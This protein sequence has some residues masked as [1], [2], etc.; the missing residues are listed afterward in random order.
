MIAQEFQCIPEDGSVVASLLN[1][2]GEVIVS[3]RS[4]HPDS[5]WMLLEAAER[6]RAA[7]ALLLGYGCTD[8]VEDRQMAT[9]RAMRERG[10]MVAAMLIVEGKQWQD[11][12]SGAGGAVE[13]VEVVRLSDEGVQTEPGEP[14]NLTQREIEARVQ[15]VAGAV[16]EPGD[17][18]RGEELLAAMAAG[19]RDRW[20]DEEVAA[21]GAALQDILLRDVIA[22]G[23]LMQPD[24]SASER[25][26][27]V[28]ALRELAVRL[29]GPLAAE[30]LVLLALAAWCDRQV[31]LAR[32]ALNRLSTVAPTHRL[33]TLLGQLMMLGP[34]S[35]LW[36]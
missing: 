11:R 19:A 31:V 30:A 18:E 33:G 36:K 34:A 17:A 35:M 7:V 15:P 25:T 26:R 6:S 29:D 21:M 24:N 22:A 23:W 13:P 12:V 4:S 28:E 14:V 27:A 1:G 5:D 32:A 16:R 20:S 2:D 8:D 9:A 3:A 10:V